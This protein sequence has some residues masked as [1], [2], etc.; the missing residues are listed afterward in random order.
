MKKKKHKKILLIEDDKYISFAYKEGFTKAGFDVC[1]INNG[2]GV[3]GIMNNYKPDLVI[4]DLV[5]PKRDGFEVL[6]DINEYK[7]LKVIPVVVLTNLVEDFFI[8]D[9]KKYQIASLLTKNSCSMRYVI[10]RVNKILD[11]KEE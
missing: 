3:I 4:L 10:E 7:E 2:S 11:N 6:A 8:K 5:M 1:H 9:I